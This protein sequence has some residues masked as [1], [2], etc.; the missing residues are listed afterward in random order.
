M[1]PTLQLVVNIITITGVTSLVGYCYL[2]KKDRRKLAGERKEPSGEVDQTLASARDAA[3]EQDIRTFAST[4]RNRWVNG[5]AS[6]I[7][8]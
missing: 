6:S 7:S 8:R 5:M 3:V 1:E 4:S 2:L